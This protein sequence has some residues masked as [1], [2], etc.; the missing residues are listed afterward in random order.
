MTK[1][2]RTKKKLVKALFFVLTAYA[3]VT[4]LQRF[5]FKPQMPVPQLST[6]QADY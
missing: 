4:M 6:V 1:A 3:V 2:R 5:N